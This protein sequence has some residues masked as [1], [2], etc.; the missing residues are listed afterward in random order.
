MTGSRRH[1]DPTRVLRGRFAFPLALL[2]VTWA[3]AC[4]GDG[5]TEP[6]PPTQQPNRPP[7]AS[8]SIPAQTIT[9]GESVTVNLGNVFSDP[10]GGTLT[11]TAISS[12][13]GVATASVS[14]ANLT[15]AAVAAGTTTVTATARD[16]AGL[17]TAASASV[18]VTEPNRAPVA[19]VP[20]A[21]AQTATVGDT[22]RVDATPFF[23]D[24]DGDALTFAATSGNASVV[25][26][27]VEG[28]VVA[29]EALAVGATDVTVTASDPDG[30][31]AS[32][33]VPVTVE[34]NLPPETTQNSLP[35]MEIQERDSAVVK[36]ASYFTDPNGQTLT[37]SAESADTTVATVSVSN[38]TLTV[39]AVTIGPSN[40]TVTATD[41]RGLTATLS[42]SVTVIERVNRAPEAVS[43]ISPVEAT[44]G[45]SGGLDLEGEEPLFVDPDG[46]ALTYSAESSDS[47]VVAVGV[48]EG[49]LLAVRLDAVG[50]AVATVTAT[51][52]GGL[53]ASITFD[54]TVLPAAAM[55]FRDDFD[56]DTSLDDWE[57]GRNAEAE[58][59]RRASSALVNAA[60]TLWGIA[61]HEL[62][63]PTTSWGDPDP[64]LGRQVRFEVRK[65]RVDDCRHPMPGERNTEALR[66]EVGSHVL[67]FGDGGTETVD[68][69]L[70]RIFR[71]RRP[72]PRLVLHW[73]DGDIDFRGTSD[74]INDGPGEFTEIT[75]RVQDGIFEAL[76]GADFAL[77]YSSRA[78]LSFGDALAKISEIHLWT[79]ERV[80]TTDP[81]LLDWIEVNGVASDDW[82]HHHR[83]R[84]QTTAVHPIGLV[85]GCARPGPDRDAEHT[86]GRGREA[87]AALRDPKL[88]LAATATR[89]GRRRAGGALSP[90]GPGAP[91]PP[92][93]AAPPWPAR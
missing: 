2:A 55:I 60:D 50:T 4:G 53:S 41:P 3:A 16:P 34:A 5:G 25:S 73:T 36:L 48:L 6:P 21:P 40:V 74:A 75:V 23:S 18:T 27:S 42:G 28:S 33:S 20:V 51:D 37:Y 17:S 49:T 7:V 46:D 63:T 71:A 77:H 93:P 38:D 43:R 87:V 9:A 90:G 19:A 62:E 31:F 44:V 79:Y 83:P 8:G 66:L 72:R 56:D 29:A 54:V 65:N 45:W 80:V 26:V 47:A 59:L 24:P 81:S 22:V 68:Y 58:V 78:Q 88:P 35:S 61:A 84:P 52:P 10:D 39:R 70:V 92:L 89:A 12:S 82:L 30:L 32:V 76:A 85:G 57:I 14:G 1:S 11:Y 91:P 69:A 64:Q 15:I 13:P 67:D 86:A